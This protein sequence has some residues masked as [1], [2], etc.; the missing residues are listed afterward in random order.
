V[1]HSGRGGQMLW[2]NEKPRLCTVVI[3]GVVA[4]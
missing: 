3:E 2:L 1:R 4:R